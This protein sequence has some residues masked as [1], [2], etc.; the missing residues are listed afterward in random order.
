MKAAKIFTQ[1]HAVSLT[2]GWCFWWW[3]I[4]YSPENVE[5]V[6]PPLQS[7]KPENLKIIVQE[8]LQYQRQ[9]LGTCAW[10]LQGANTPL[11]SRLHYF[12]WPMDPIHRCDLQTTPADPLQIEAIFVDIL[13]IKLLTQMGNQ[14]IGRISFKIRISKTKYWIKTVFLRHI[15]IQVSV[16]YGLMPENNASHML[17]H[18]ILIKCRS[19]HAFLRVTIVKLSFIS[20]STG[21]N[22]VLN[23]RKHFGWVDFTIPCWW[24]REA[25]R[26]LLNSHTGHFNNCVLQ[27]SHSKSWENTVR[28]KKLCQLSSCFRYTVLVMT[29]PVFWHTNVPLYLWYSLWSKTYP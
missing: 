17:V 25:Q 1:S 5:P 11:T 27:V 12:L 24:A 28:L 10:W 7:K 9:V 18:F 16:I 26:A 29:F 13:G 22:D 14:N 4:L 19:F 3:Q 8:I 6:E 21:R 23:K 2:F 20:T 15:L